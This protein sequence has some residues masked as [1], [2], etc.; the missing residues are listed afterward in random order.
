VWFQSG[1]GDELRAADC[2]TMTPDGSLWAG[3]DGD[4]LQVVLLTQERRQKVLLQLTGQPYS[5][6]T[7]VAFSPD[8]QRLYFNS[9]RGPDTLYNSAGH[10]ISYELQG[11]FLSWAKT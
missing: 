11:D 2:M 1:V 8:Y 7:G 10:G 4:D 9:Q 3:E 5:E 6:I